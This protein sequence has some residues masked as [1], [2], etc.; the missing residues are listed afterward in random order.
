MKSEMRL[1]SGAGGEAGFRGGRRGIEGPG[2]SFDNVNRHPFLL[3]T[4][5]DGVAFSSKELWT[6][7][8]EGESGNGRTDRAGGLG[9]GAG[10]D[11]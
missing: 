5:I 1:H 2:I 7:E 8:G 6:G 11:G 3:L 9:D 4:W 10:A